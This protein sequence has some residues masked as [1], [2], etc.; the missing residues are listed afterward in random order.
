MTKSAEEILKEFAKEVD[1][2]INLEEVDYSCLYTLV[3]KIIRLAIKDFIIYELYEQGFIL[4]RY[5][6]QKEQ[7]IAFWGKNAR[8]FLFSHKNLINFLRFYEME[9]K[10]NAQ[11]IRKYACKLLKDLKRN[12]IK[13]KGIL[14]EM[15]IERINDK[16]M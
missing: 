12:G 6:K 4:E 2:I 9:D 16:R 7:E 10:V 11:Y 1:G 13:I 5:S 8:G 15:E 3:G 14:E